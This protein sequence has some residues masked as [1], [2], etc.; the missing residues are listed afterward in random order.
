M[1]ELDLALKLSDRCVTAA[2]IRIEPA[3]ITT[4]V[5]LCL[6]LLHKV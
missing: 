1:L 3:F 6:R 5:A 4:L 2:R